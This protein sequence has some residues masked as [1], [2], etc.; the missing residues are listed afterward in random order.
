MIKISERMY[1]AVG[2]AFANS[3]MFVGTT[4]IVIID[5]TENEEAT[6]LIH[7]DFRKIT[8]KPLVGIIYTHNHVDHVSGTASFFDNGTRPD[9]LEIWAHHSL[10]AQYHQSMRTMGE[11]HFRRSMRQFGGFLQKTQSS[12]GFNTQLD[13]GKPKFII[14]PNKFLYKSMQDISLGNDFAA[15]PRSRGNRRPDCCVLAGRKGAAVWRR[16]L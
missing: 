16:L 14:P 13:V 7:Q 5:T 12:R 11:A 4:G 15:L 2:Y 10:M 6:K 3:I 8:D 1:V 9:N